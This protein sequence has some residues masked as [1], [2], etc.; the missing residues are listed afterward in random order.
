MHFS[1]KQLHYLIWGG[2]VHS[3]VEWLPPLPPPPASCW[4]FLK[5]L[6]WVED[7]AEYSRNNIEIW[8]WTCDIW[9]F[10]LHPDRFSSA[11]KRFKISSHISLSLLGRAR[12]Q[13]RRSKKS[14]KRANKDFLSNF[15][16]QNLVKVQRR[17]FLGWFLNTVACKY[18]VMLV[19]N[20]LGQRGSIVYRG[21]TW[22]LCFFFTYPRQLGVRS[23]CR[24]FLNQLETW[25][26]V[27]PVFLA[28]AFFSSGV[29]YRLS[30]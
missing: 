10:C 25:V 23:R 7:D 16:A 22:S 11:P 29:G 9:S 18:V 2:W 13:C 6:L 24:R 27:S 28:K 17:F 4:H 1:A 8:S 14:L 15:C 21:E 26:R 3:I 5:L 30:L 19:I 12:C 20:L